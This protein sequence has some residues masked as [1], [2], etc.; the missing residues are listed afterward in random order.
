MGM[1]RQVEVGCVERSAAG[2]PYQTLPGGR[3]EGGTLQ[4]SAEHRLGCAYGIPKAGGFGV[5]GGWVPVR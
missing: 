1:D 2:H 3:M 5:Q 4:G